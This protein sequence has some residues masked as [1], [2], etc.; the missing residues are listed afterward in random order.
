MVEFI[1]LPLPSS[2]KL[3]IWLFHVVVVQGRQRSVQKS[4]MHVQSCCFANL[5]LL[6]FEAAVAVAVAVEERKETRKRG[7][8][9]HAFSRGSLRSLKYERELARRPDQRGATYTI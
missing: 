2:K 9:A 5:I 6:L 3:K 4:V 7:P 1:A 8:I